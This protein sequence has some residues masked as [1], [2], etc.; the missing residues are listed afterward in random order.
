MVCRGTQSR[1]AQHGVTVVQ[2]A[3]VNSAYASTR[4]AHG[5]TVRMVDSFEMTNSS[6]AAIRRALSRGYH[7]TCHG[8]H[9]RRTSRLQVVT[10]LCTGVGNNEA[11]VVPHF[12]ARE[13][14]AQ[15]D[16][17]EVLSR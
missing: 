1:A 9:N 12:N 11:H 10:R 16:I 2:I 6:P 13:F 3:P 5:V 8:S 14:N 4:S 17:R 15:R 7:L